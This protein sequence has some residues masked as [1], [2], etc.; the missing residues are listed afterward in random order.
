MN[1]RVHV[2]GMRVGDV[3]ESA[4]WEPMEVVTKNAGPQQWEVGVK[5]TNTGRAA[6]LVMRTDAYV[7]VIERNR[8]WRS[9]KPAPGRNKR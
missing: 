4:G 8:D 3:I 6:E 9:T 2:F 1:E 7:F 5:G